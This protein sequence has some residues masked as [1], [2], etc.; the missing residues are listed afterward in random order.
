M[1]AGKSLWDATWSEIFFAIEQAE[2]RWQKSGEGKK[3]K[4]WVISNVLEYIEGKASLSWYQRKVIRLFISMVAD[5]IV[6]TINQEVGH[7][8][9]KKIKSLERELEEKTPFF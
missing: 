5:S 1:Q 2:T 6:K 9:V 4:E 8:W 3:K 7:G